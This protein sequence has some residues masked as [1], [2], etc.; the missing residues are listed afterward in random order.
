M[1]VYIMRPFDTNFIYALY[2]HI[3]IIA[4]RRPRSVI[5]KLR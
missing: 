5:T 3:S 2:S 4:N 1:G